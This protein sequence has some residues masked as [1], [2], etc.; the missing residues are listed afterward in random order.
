MRNANTTMDQGD[1]YLGN[2]D[3]AAFNAGLGRPAR[4]IGVSV[5]RD[6]LDARSTILGLTVTL[7]NL[8]RERDLQERQDFGGNGRG[9][10]ADEDDLAAQERSDL[11]GSTSQCEKAKESEY[12]WRE[13]QRRTLANTRRSHTAWVYCPLCFKFHNFWLKALRM[14]A[15]L[16]PGASTVAALSAW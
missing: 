8:A 9:S 5:A 16:A 2:I 12:K 13:N 15:P 7:R 4:P 1:T 10:R 11:E 14:R 3:E 6:A